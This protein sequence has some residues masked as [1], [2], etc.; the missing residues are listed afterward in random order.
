MKIFYVFFNEIKKNTISIF[1][2][3][4]AL[5]TALLCFASGIYTDPET[6]RTYSVFECLF[7]FDYDFMKSNYEFSSILVF[8]KGLNEYLLMFMPVLSA[9]SFVLNFNSEFE[10][11]YY[12][13]EIC[14]TR[15][16]YL[17]FSKFFS[18]L[19]NGGLVALAGML[20]F[21]LIS[22][23]IFP[24]FNSFQLEPELR[25]LLISENAIVIVLKMLAGAFLYGMFSASLSIILSVLI[26]NIYVVLCLP[27]MI[28]YMYNIAL[29]KLMLSESVLYNQERLKNLQFLYPHSIIYIFNNPSIINSLW[30]NITFVFIAFGIFFMILNRKA[31]CK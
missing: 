14:R 25:Q 12:R 27:F 15:K 18:G 31:D 2:V 30:L 3:I 26:R 21:G 23:I 13:Y 28:T 10:S 22:F 5:I 6:E 7:T 8:E 19:L 1:F 17:I 11:T 4:S 29:N 20:L 24:D 16:K 9:C